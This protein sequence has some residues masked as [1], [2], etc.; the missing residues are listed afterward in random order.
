MSF[1]PFSN[2]NNSSDSNQDPDVNFFL[3]NILS[4]NSEYFSLSD[5]KIG[6]SK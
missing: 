2:N 3:D 1:N 5:V 4:F 6:F